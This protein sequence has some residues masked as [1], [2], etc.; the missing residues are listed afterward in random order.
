MVAHVIVG[1]GKLRSESSSAEVFDLSC[2]LAVAQAAWLHNH[3]TRA[4]H[5]FPDDLLASGTTLYRLARRRRVRRDR[6][7][8][9]PARDWPPAWTPGLPTVGHVVIRVD[10][11]AEGSRLGPRYRMPG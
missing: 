8:S 4:R 2:G 10:E 7:C 5:S 1:G 3:D 11:R 6:S 9:H